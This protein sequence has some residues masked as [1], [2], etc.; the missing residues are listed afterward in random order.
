LKRAVQIAFMLAVGGLALWATFRSRVD[1][2]AFSLGVAA[3]ATVHIT[4]SIRWGLLVR[5]VAPQVGFR[6]YFAICSIGF[7]LINIL[8]FR[9]GEFVRPFLLYE[10]EEVPFGSGLATVVVERVLDVAALGVIF[11]SV[12]AFA[13]LPEATVMAGGD[14]YDVVALGR[15][16]ILGT[17]LPVTAVLAVLILLGDRGVELTRRLSAPL[18][19]RLSALAARFVETFVDALKSMGTVSRTWGSGTARPSWSASASS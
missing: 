3:F 7:F 12:L 6:S 19:P 1:W 15:A 9:L 16:T 18:G 5:G 8:P 4:R 2:F 11:L 10:R 17:L 13:D 14:E